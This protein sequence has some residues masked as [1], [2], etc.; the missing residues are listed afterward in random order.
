MDSSPQFSDFTKK[1]C[2]T[3][4]SI[5]PATTEYFHCDKNT[6]DGLGYSCKECV[7]ARRKRYYLQNREKAIEYSKQYTAQHREQTAQ[8]QKQY[9]EQH[10]ADLAEYKKVY[11]AEHAEENRTRSKQWYKEHKQ[12]VSKEKPE[13]D[14][15]YSEEHAAFL[16]ICKQCNCKLP[17][18]SEYFPINKGYK[19]GLAAICKPCAAER[20]REYYQQHKEQIKAYGKQYVKNNVHKVKVYKRKYADNNSEKMQQSRRQ[21]EANNPEKVKQSKRQY[22]EKKRAELLLKKV[23][24]KLYTDNGGCEV[25]TGKKRCFKCQR[26]LPATTEYFGNQKR[27][28]DGFYYMCKECCKEQRAA[29]KEQKSESDRRYRE[30]NRVER[31]A[32]KREYSQKHAEELASKQREYYEE[33]KEA[34]LA[35]R[36]AYYQTERGIIAKRAGSHNRRARKKKAQGKHTT[37]QLY[38][39]LKKQEGKCYYCKKDVSP[40]R[41]SWHADHYIPLSKGGSNDINNIVISCPTCNLR[42]NDKLPHEWANEEG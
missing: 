27:A 13:Q 15:E 20:S 28:K 19:D 23:Q 40:N 39:Q 14:R 4:Q 29:H 6:K 24:A 1:Q 8:Y 32:K 36:K 2:R 35:Y 18:T 37:E 25:E 34:R 41:N 22:E 10:E 38:Q 30:R 7:K 33:N 11:Y 31:L 42:K 12:P 17:A 9:A 16:K 21:Y 3:C 5:L 26:F